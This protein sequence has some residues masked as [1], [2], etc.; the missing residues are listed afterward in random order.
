MQTIP[1][2]NDLSYQKLMETLDEK[3]ISNLRECMFRVCPEILID[4]HKEYKQLL[5]SYE[6]ICKVSSKKKRD[7]KS[8]E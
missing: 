5:D 4:F 6:K 1:C 3:G 7:K 8:A 2:D